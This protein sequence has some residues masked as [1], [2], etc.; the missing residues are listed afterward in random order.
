[1]RTEKHSNP[2]KSPKCSCSKKECNVSSGDK[3]HMN[4]HSKP[5][6][7]TC[8][9][10][11]S[12]TQEMEALRINGGVIIG[13]AHEKGL[14]N[15]WQAEPYGNWVHLTLSLE[16]SGLTKCTFA[17]VFV[18]RSSSSLQDDGMHD[19]IVKSF[20]HRTSIFWAAFTNIGVGRGE[21]HTEFS[22]F[23]TSGQ[24][25]CHHR[26]H[27]ELLPGTEHSAKVAE[28]EMESAHEPRPPPSRLSPDDDDDEF[29][30]FRRG[31]SLLVNRRKEQ[32]RAVKARVCDSLIGAK[33][34][35]ACVSHEGTSS[36]GGE[37]TGLYGAA[38]SKAVEAC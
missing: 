3:K 2:C 27:K 14:T 29:Y 33:A 8:D 25:I 23:C 15:Y 17:E 31:Q 35:G 24:P 32:W 4:R 21:S 13:P 34:H 6:G 36:R 22:K 28:Q 10:V 11:V 30:G 19:Y 20:V 12:R 37:V 38:K 5:Y 26:Q 1:M 16:I 9:R 18:D 7:C